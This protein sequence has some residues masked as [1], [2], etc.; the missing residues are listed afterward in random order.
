MWTVTCSHCNACMK[1]K[2]PCFGTA[3]IMFGPM[4]FLY[5]EVPVWSGWHIAAFAMLAFVCVSS[6]ILGLIQVH[7]V[8]AAQSR[9]TVGFGLLVCAVL[10]VAAILIGGLMIAARAG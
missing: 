8:R 2:Y 6:F 1:K 3:V 9:K 7:T 5:S 4:A 10:L